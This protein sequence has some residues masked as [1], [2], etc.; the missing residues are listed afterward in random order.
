MFIMAVI[1]AGF[2]R[3]LFALYQHSSAFP[4][5]SSQRFM[6]VMCVLA[7]LGSVTL[8]WRYCFAIAC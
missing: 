5:S 7:G 6:E 3:L 4:A 1:L 2:S 8:A